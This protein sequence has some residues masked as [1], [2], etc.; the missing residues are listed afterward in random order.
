VLGKVVRALGLKGHLGVAGSDGVLQGLERVTLRRPGEAGAEQVVVE[1]RPQGRLWAL[2]VSGVADRSAAEAWVGAE[3]L[4]RREDLGEAGAGR[5]WWADLRGLPVSTVT[6]RSLGV[7][8][9]LLET[10]AVDVLVVTGERGEVLVPL[11]PYVEVDLERGRVVV[12][13]PAGLLED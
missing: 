2:R 11:A 13:P 10:G 5:Y 9:G 6:G 4:A 3:V 1:A 12:D 8:S 7:V